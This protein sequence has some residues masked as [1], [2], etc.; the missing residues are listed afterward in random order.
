MIFSQIKHIITNEAPS[1]IITL[2]N[3]PPELRA[4]PWLFGGSGDGDGAGDDNDNNVGGDDGDGNG[5]GGGEWGF[6]LDLLG[7][8]NTASFNP[9]WQWA[10]VPHMM[11]FDPG[12]VSD[13]LEF[14]SLNTTCWVP[15]VMQSE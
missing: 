15:L 12:S 5:D 10:C 4:T 3:P 11:Y 13:T 8:T 7:M 2:T 9:S 6:F 1:H 14:P